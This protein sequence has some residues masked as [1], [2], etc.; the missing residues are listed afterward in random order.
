MVAAI[1][2]RAYLNEMGIDIWVR[3]RAPAAE[4]ATESR[5]P[6]PSP[7]LDAPGVDDDKMCLL[8]YPGVV[9]L[10]RPDQR[11]MM[12]APRERQLC[13]DIAMAANG[14]KVSGAISIVTLAELLVKAPANLVI[15]GDVALD[16]RA[17]AAQFP[18]LSEVM[19]SAAV[20]RSLWQHISKI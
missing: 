12:L 16:D 10:V 6:E 9:M 4:P 11:E 20:K 15:F 19:R 5:E 13:D 8:E 7:H 14:A 2:K 3:R 17:Q 1:N 18:S